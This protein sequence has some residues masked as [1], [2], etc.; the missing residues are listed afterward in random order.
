MKRTV[1]PSAVVPESGMV[2]NYRYRRWNSDDRVQYSV[3]VYALVCL[4]RPLLLEAPIE[5][6]QARRIAQIANDW[7]MRFSTEDINYTLLLL[8]GE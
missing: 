4:L 6:Q 2:L 3:W 7:A 5:N 1:C 8:N